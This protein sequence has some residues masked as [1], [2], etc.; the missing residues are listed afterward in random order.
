MVCT[1]AGASPE[2]RDVFQEDVHTKPGINTL[3]TFSNI[4]NH[5][6]EVHWPGMVPSTQH[7]IPET[8]PK[9]MTWT[10][11]TIIIDEHPPQPRRI[12][13]VAAVD[14]DQ[15][16]KTDLWFSGSH[17]PIQEQKSA[18]YK[19]TGDP[20]RW[21]RYTPFP[22]PSLGAAWGDVDGDG[23][24]D[25]ITGGDRNW[26][27]TD[28]YAMVWLENPL[29]PDGD[30]CQG[31]WAVHQIHTDPADPDEIHADFIDIKG[32]KQQG[33]DL[34]HDSR[35]DIIV[36][37]FKQSLWYVPGPKDPKQ[38]PWEFH[39][40]AEAD[41][42]HGGAAIVD[43]DQDGDLDIVWGIEWYENPGN[44]CAGL[45]AKHII[46]EDWTHETQVE[47]ADLDKDGRLDV[48]L[49]GEETDHGLAWYRNPGVA[50][51]S[52]WPRHQLLS[53]WTGLH[54][55]ELADFD[56]DGDLDVFTAQ[57]HHTKEKRVTIV[58]NLD[59]THNIWRVHIIDTCGSHKALV[60][61]IDHDGDI[62][63]VGKNYEKDTRPRIWLN[64]NVGKK[65]RSD[66]PWVK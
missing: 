12:T 59:L 21:K 16:G 3:Y 65:D 38:G 9:S 49:S 26:A 24:M 43:L 4:L 11:E 1:A 6:L 35:L 15:D 14:I 56:K 17:I 46:D 45:W 2:F 47:I 19:N 48:V 62:D 10:F 8:D 7:D 57:M 28:N 64:P 13:D 27:Q 30:P 55:L 63:I 40:I 58:E 31:P 25:L 41:D 29:Y 52:P 5:G 42:G 34:N 51:I 36:A 54:S 20:L 66:K 37:A 53:G 32:Q 39:K 23:D 33:L 18:W 22:G 60:C 61:D 44:P 50:S